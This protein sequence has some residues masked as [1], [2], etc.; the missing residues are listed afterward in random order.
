MKGDPHDPKALIREA[1]RIDG[2]TEAECRTI[3]LEWALEVQDV[4]GLARLLL[5]RHAGEPADHPMTRLLHQ[6]QTTSSEPR[7]RGGR[8]GRLA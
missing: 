1:Y 7:R 5:D 4:A 6:A 8:A 3:F 2:I